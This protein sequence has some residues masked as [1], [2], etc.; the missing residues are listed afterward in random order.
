ME[1]HRDYCADWYLKRD[2]QGQYEVAVDR[3]LLPMRI[4]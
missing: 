3:L 1:E 4:E 2:A